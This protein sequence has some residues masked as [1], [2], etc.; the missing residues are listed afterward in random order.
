MKIF[1]IGVGNP[2][3]CRTAN[4]FNHQCYLFEANPQIYQQ[5][6]QS[7]G[8]RSNFHIYNIAIADYDGEIDFLCNGDSSFISDIKSPASRGNNEYLNTFKKIKVPCQKISNFENNEPIDLMLLDMEGSEWY[9]L[10]NL[11]GKPKI[12][13]IEMQ[14]EDKT[15][16]NPFFEEILKWMK[17]NNYILKG[18]NQIEEDW[19]F[20]KQN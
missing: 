14:N 18:K 10:K 3:I 15:Y 1:E 9:V 11:K 17:E 20:E 2:S 5:L 7:Y 12:I 13:V 8:N 16:K 6:V 19:Y 4:E